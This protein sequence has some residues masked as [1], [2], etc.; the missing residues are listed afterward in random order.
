[1]DN[2]NDL[3]NWGEKIQSE[4]NLVDSDSFQDSSLFYIIIKA[5]QQN[6]WFTK[7][8][9]LLALQNCANM[10]GESTLNIWWNFY[11]NKKESFNKQK[12]IALIMAGNIPAVGFQDLLYI[13]LTG[14][15]AQIKLSSEDS[16]LIPF[17]LKYLLEINKEWGKR[18]E[19]VDKVKDFD[20]VIATGSNN[21][22]R[23]FEYY[24][25]K[26]PNLIRKSRTSI[27]HIDG[28]E[29]EFDWKNLQKD[30][31]SYFGMGCRNVNFL[32]ILN[33][34]E[35]ENV[36]SKL[37]PEFQNNFKQH[38]K[39]LNN[40]D[41]HKSVCLI[42]KIPF[43]DGGTVL[44]RESRE[45]FSPLSVIHYS[46]FKDYNEWNEFIGINEGNIQCVI[47]DKNKQGSI[48]FGESQLPNLLDYPDNVDVT[49]FILGLN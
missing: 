36:I 1:M 7:D 21:S 3:V 23:Y 27:A 47:G 18:V 46:F 49:E 4:L 26:F 45:I 5:N 31:Y 29:T 10:L 35:I 17:L 20:A 38:H 13:L 48:K 39:Y 34:V 42:N 12:K 14:N 30:I 44:F 32:G 37:E 43:L 33:G 40:L 8:N 15:H 9:I 41:Y 24:F 25:G 11:S 2:L 6:P 28:T 19:I 22:A 16:F